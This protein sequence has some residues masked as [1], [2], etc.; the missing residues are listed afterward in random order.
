MSPRA[1]RY[2]RFALAAVVAR[3]LFGVGFKVLALST[4]RPERLGEILA[5]TVRGMTLLSE[6]F[7]LLP[8]LL[9]AAICAS[10]P[11]RLLGRAIGLFALG[12]VG[13]V[14]IYFTSYMSFEAYMQQHSWT[15]AILATASVSYKCLVVV[16]VAALARLA[17][18][19]TK[20]PVEV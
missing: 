16:F 12:L 2:V 10:L 17:L 11:T 7:D 4:Y 5:S 3:A 15:A 14:P 9:L 20:L 1:T 6:A 8:F 19:R 13:F 18:G